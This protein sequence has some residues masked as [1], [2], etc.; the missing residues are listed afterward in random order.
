MA[1]WEEF[2]KIK[3]ATKKAAK[4]A[5]TLNKMHYTISIEKL[6]E[7]AKYTNFSTVDLTQFMNPVRRMTDKEIFNLV[8]SS[9]NVEGVLFLPF[10]FAR[11][12][13]NHIFGEDE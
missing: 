5:K 8:D 10:S 7:L 4:V 12:V 13:E 9:K 11:E 1:T 6:Q 3:L 2:T